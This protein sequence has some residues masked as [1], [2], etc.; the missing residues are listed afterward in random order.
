MLALMEC[1]H[2]D[3]LM[4]VV[5]MVIPRYTI[6]TP[7]HVTAQGLYLCQIKTNTGAGQWL[8]TIARGQDVYEMRPDLCREYWQ[9]SAL[10]YGPG[11][12][13]GRG[14]NLD[15]RGEGE[16]TATLY[17]AWLYTREVTIASMLASAG[18]EERRQRARAAGRRLDEMLRYLPDQPKPR[19]NPQTPKPRAATP[20]P[21]LPADQL[22]LF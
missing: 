9:V 3:Q 4:G 20:A 10:L 19:S 22:T 13:I 8:L 6:Y 15:D 2:I 11:W 17:E 5:D 21:A 14:A 12:A 1:A 16:H 7:P 18:A